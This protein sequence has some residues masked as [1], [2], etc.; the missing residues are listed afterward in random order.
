MWDGWPDPRCPTPALWI[1]GK[2]LCAWGENVERWGELLENRPA[3]GGP[4]CPRAYAPSPSSIP[5]TFATRAAK[6]ASSRM[7][8]WT[9]SRL[10]ITVE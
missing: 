8:S 6:F 1:A 4:P 7:V 3:V 9:R 5:R 10:W 2:K